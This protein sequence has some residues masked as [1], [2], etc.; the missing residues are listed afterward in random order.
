MTTVSAKLR[1]RMGDFCATAL[2]N[3]LNYPIGS[4]LIL[5]V[6]DRGRH[7]PAELT[8]ARHRTFP[9]LVIHD[10]QLTALAHVCERNGWRVKIETRFPIGGGDPYV[11]NIQIV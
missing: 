8:T 4:D 7:R 11:C 3:V 5:S 10:R 1:E 2:E 6:K 9:L